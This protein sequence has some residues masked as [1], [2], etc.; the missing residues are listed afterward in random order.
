MSAVHHVWLRRIGACGSVL[1]AAILG[2]SMLLRLTTIFDVGGHTVS[3]LPPTLEHAARL[4]H[5]LAASGVVLLALWSV[6]YCWMRRRSTA[7]LHGPIAWVLVSTVILALIGPLTPGYRLS[8]ITV[9]NVTGGMALL[10]AFWWLRESAAIEVAV[11]K[12]ADAFAWVAVIAFGAHIGTGAA[13]SAWAMHGVRWPALLHLGSLVLCIIL[14]GAFALEQ[15]RRR[16]RSGCVALLATLFALQG[17]IG[18]ALMSQDSRQIGLSLFHAMLSPLL[19]VTL[20][21]LVNR[22]RPAGSQGK[23]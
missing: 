9:A 7:H 4:L 15:R 6:I 17:T 19:A 10:M 11:R 22:S 13:A 14:V 2:A 5:R 3:I 21:S 16:A 1:A 8:V 23:T 20:V 18:Y 12:P